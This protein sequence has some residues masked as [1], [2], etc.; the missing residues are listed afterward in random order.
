MPDARA[1]LYEDVVDLLLWRWEAVKLENEDEQET[2]WRKLLQDANL[3][4]IELKQVLWKLAYTT[5]GQ[6][7]D[8]ANEAAADIPESAL[9]NVLRELHPKR[10]LD[11]ADRLNA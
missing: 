5:H 4:D 6:Q 2:T 7:G 3:N 10:S 11:W 9:L 8:A 1:L